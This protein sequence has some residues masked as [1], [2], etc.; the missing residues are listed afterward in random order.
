MG[1]DHKSEGAMIKERST[2]ITELDGELAHQIDRLGATM[3]ELMRRLEPI[4]TPEPTTAPG[5]SQVDSCGPRSMVRA[6]LGVYVARLQSIVSDADS[7]LD[8]LDL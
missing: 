7:L 5:N 3:T 4:L 6:S 2:V 8:R 1:Y